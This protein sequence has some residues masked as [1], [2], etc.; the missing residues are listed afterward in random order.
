MLF[1]D[2]GE[3][4]KMGKQGSINS[5]LSKKAYLQYMGDYIVLYESINNLRGRKWLIRIGFRCR[6]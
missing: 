2:S 4:I 5:T 6:K 1:H 3:T